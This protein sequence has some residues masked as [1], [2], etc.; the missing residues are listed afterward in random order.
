M[1][2]LYFMIT[3]LNVRDTRRFLSCLFPSHSSHFLA[4]MLCNHLYLASSFR[5]TRLLGSSQT[6]IFWVLSNL[7]VKFMTQ[8]E[9]KLKEAIVSLKQGSQSI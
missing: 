8:L 6:G 9:P 5:T 2:I 4:A 1:F 7:F 3:F